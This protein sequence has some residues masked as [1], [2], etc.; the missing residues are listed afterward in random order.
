MKEKILLALIMVI[1][2]FLVVKQVDV[3][4]RVIA[5]S[6]PKTTTIVA[7]EVTEAIK[8]NKKLR[9]EL[10]SLTNEKK[11]LLNSSTSKIA[12]DESLTKE[13]QQLK[14]ATGQTQVTGPGVEIKF[15]S[16]LQLTQLVDLINALRNIGAEAI[17]INGIRIV[18][19]T[20]ITDSLG[21]EPVVIKAIGNKDVLS[22]SLLRRGGIIEQIAAS[23]KVDK[24]DKLVLAKIKGN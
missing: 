15:G 10:E 3:R 5:T 9:Q 4:S 2:G 13:I 23:G 20:P 18:A 24:Q 8:G 12:S 11:A 1:F 22:D 21:S 16:S 19:N 6:D 14:I 17:D 7:T